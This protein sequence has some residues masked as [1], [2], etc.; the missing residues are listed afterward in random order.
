MKTDTRDTLAIDYEYT[1]LLDSASAF[2]REGLHAT[3]PY[4]NHQHSLIVMYLASKYL[5]HSN[6]SYSPAT[7]FTLRLAALFHDYNHAGDR[8][9]V[10]SDLDNIASAIKGFTR[11][12]YKVNLASPIVSTVIAAI[13]CTQYDAKTSSMPIEPKT[14]IQKALRDADVTNILLA[15]GRQLLWKL[16]TELAY[17]SG[18]GLWDIHPGWRSATIT[19]LS[20]ITL[21]TEKAQELALDGTLESAIISF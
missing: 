9:K 12:A 2:C 20:G 19:F 13:Q 7:L 5:A 8:I 4:H 15:E 1:K 21:Y 6:N 17:Q 3:N 11:W 18:K 14:D 10:E 16:P